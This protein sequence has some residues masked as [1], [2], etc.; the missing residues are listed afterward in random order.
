MGFGKVSRTDRIVLRLYVHAPTEL[1]CTN[2]ASIQMYLM[3]LISFAYLHMYGYGYARRL[4][5]LDDG[6]SKCSRQ[7]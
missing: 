4:M 7:N 3:Y 1:K 5:E 2:G 6:A